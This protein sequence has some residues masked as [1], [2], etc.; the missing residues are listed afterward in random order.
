MAR[1][2]HE[3]QVGGRALTLS[4]LDKVLWPRDGYTKGD[5]IAYYRAVAKWLLPHL[6][7]RPLTLQR[8]P[9]GIDKQSFFEKQAPK[10]TPEWIPT[11]ALSADQQS[12]K[13]SYILCN[14]EATLV[15]CVNL[16]SIVLHVWYSHVPTT[17]NPD[18]ALFDLDTCERTTMK[19]LVTVA[20]AFRE[21][22]ASIGLPCLIKTSGGSGFHV[23]IPLKPKY[24]YDTIKQFAEIAARHIAAQLPDLTTLERSVSKRPKTAVYLDWVQVGRGKTVVPPYVV[25]ARDG[26]PV[27]MPLDWSEVEALA[28]KRST[29]EATFAQW[30]MKNAA[31]RLAGEG[32][33]WGPKF[34]KPAAL[35]PALKKAQRAWT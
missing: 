29:P 11:V 26:A 6:K 20:V 30:T 35:E 24:G 13:V 1:T 23:V 2:T 32:D 3:I 12:R 28:K 34:W 15:W 14:E 16:A 22:L 7:D 9:D 25:R 18:Y 17:D 33:L 31:K 8:W 10:Y 27:S 5:L 21:A 4:N 19:S